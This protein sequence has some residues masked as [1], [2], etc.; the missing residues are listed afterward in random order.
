VHPG[1]RLAARKA[2]R[3]RSLSLFPSSREVFRGVV[4]HCAIDRL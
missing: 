1:I 3:D 2:V 4:R